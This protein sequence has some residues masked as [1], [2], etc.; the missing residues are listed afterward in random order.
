MVSQPHQNQGEVC[1][2]KDINGLSH[3]KWRCQYLVPQRSMATQVFSEVK[4]LKGCICA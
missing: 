3:S 1:V 4:I 2:M